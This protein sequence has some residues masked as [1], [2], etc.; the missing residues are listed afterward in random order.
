MLVPVTPGRPTPWRASTAR[1][2]PSTTKRTP[3]A[4]S[5]SPG[6]SA[7]ASAAAAVSP[8]GALA[9]PTPSAAAPLAPAPAA[10]P[11][12]PSTPAPSAADA[13]KPAPPPPRAPMTTAT[14][15][16][17]IS[18]NLATLALLHGVPA[19]WPSVLDVYYDLLEALV[20][21]GGLPD[22]ADELLDAVLV[23][24]RYAVTIV[25][26]FNIVEALLVRPPPRPVEE[27]PTEVGAA[28][29]RSMSSGSPLTRPDVP[30]KRAPSGLLSAVTPASPARSPARS[31]SAS[32]SLRGESPYGRASASPLALGR[33]RPSTPFAAR[34]P[35]GTPR[36]TPSHRDVFAGR[37]V[38]RSSPA[39]TYSP[40]ARSELGTSCADTDDAREVEQALQQLR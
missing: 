13:P 21:V 11:G 1:R 33:G 2:P 16:R 37:S 35:S 31:P 29:A 27:R 25:F 19:V 18:W 10:A 3:S 38:S 15:Q 14:A 39:Y 22:G 12:A 9:Q 32:P 24:L 7:A 4:V 6:A 20:H 34:V 26:V 8:A 28:F 36:R 30:L 17:R 5:T 23:W 40:R